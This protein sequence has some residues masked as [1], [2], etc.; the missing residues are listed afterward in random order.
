MGLDA[1]A[2]L[3]QRGMEQVFPGW[4]RDLLDPRYKPYVAPPQFAVSDTP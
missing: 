1:D 4:G 2:A 3:R